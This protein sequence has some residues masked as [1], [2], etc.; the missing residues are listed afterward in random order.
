MDE[1]LSAL[2]ACRVGPIGLAD[3]SRGTTEESFMDWK[4]ALLEGLGGFVTLTEH[5][6]TY[7]PTIEISEASVDKKDNY[8]SELGEKQLHGRTGRVAYNEKNP[9]AAPIATS[10]IISSV[11]NRNCVHMEFN[12][13]EVPALRYQTG[14]HLAVWPVNPENEVERLFRLLDLDELER[15]KSSQDRIQR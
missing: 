14:D 15:T 3:E 6:I 1:T 13:S 4:E 5:P 11:P 7:E 8:L 10:R 2:G 12:L 9:Y